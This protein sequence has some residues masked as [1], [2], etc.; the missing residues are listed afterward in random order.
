VYNYGYAEA[1]HNGTAIAGYA[2]HA[3][4]GR[5]GFAEAGLN[6]HVLAGEGGRLRLWWYNGVSTIPVD[7]KIGE[8]GLEPD[9]W[10][11]LDDKGRFVRAII[12]ME[13]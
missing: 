10:Y 7:G 5:G 3:A 9:V 13:D 6:G 2:G 1:G 4:V 8:N 11:K 12:R